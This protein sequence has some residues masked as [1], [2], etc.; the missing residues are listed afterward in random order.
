MAAESGEMKCSNKYE[1]ENKAKSCR[2][3]CPFNKGKGAPE[4]RQLSYLHHLCVHWRTHQS[5]VTLCDNRLGS[6]IAT[7]HASPSFGRPAEE[8]H[9]DK[10]NSTQAA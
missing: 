10:F 7:W 5:S 8:T 1:G 2:K 9:A 6:C 3:E 4:T